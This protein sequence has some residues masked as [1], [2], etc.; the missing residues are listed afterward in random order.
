MQHTT[1]TCTEQQEQEQQEDGKTYH[2]IFCGYAALFMSV[3]TCFV[4]GSR[5]RWCDEK[6]ET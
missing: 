6:D 2:V 5:C 4:N 3:T 1:R